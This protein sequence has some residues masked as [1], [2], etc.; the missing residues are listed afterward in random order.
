MKKL[1]QSV[2]FGALVATFALPALALNEN[3]SSPVVASL[4][5]QGDAE[6]K[7]A[8]YGKFRENYKTNQPVAYE[9][10]KEYL[11][12]YPGDTDEIATYLKKW[13]AAYEK[14]S[15]KAKLPLLVYNQKNFQEAFTLGKQILADEPDDLKTLIDLGYAGFLADAAKNETFNT[16]AFG[17]ARRA[18]QLIESGKAPD[19][20]TP[21]KGKDDTL[22]YLYYTVGRLGLKNNPND[23]I[24]ALIKAAQFA[25]DIKTTPSTYYFLALAYETGPYAKQTADYKT[26]FEGKDESDAS[27]LAL[28]NLNQVIDRLIDAYA[29][30]V[31]ASGNDPK[32]AQIK[33]ESMNRLTGLYKFRHNNTDTGLTGYIAG[34]LN[35]PVPPQPTPMTALPVQPGTPASP[36]GTGNGATGTTPSGT[37]P[38]QPAQPSP[39]NKPGAA[40]PA[41]P[42]QPGSKTIAP[43][44]N[45]SGTTAGNH[46]HRRP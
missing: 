12:K 10:A 26:N 37:T 38:A 36:T 28:A 16:E 39:T 30:A 22:A 35:Q 3:A 17:Y 27:K 40:T 33:T 7:A 18:I 41:Q 44:S 8:L 1:I 11:T 15:R 34:I 19:A 9:T 6:I 13:V 23:A 45:K 21:F 4:A 32:N 42:A 5:Q 24:P 2:A 14:G 43:K 31:A 20:W 25:S 46:N 29:R